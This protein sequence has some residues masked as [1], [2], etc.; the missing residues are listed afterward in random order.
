[1]NAHQV[2]RGYER[3]DERLLALGARI[4]RGTGA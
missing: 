4:T 2:D 3:I 1:M